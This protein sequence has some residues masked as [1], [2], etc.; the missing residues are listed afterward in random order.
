MWQRLGLIAA[1]LTPAASAR[2]QSAE[3]QQEFVRGLTALHEFEYEEA[4][5]AFMK[6][7][8][9]D[10]GF[11][12]AY[13]GEAM[14]YHQSLWRHENVEMGR[15]ALRRLGPTPAARA[16]KMRTPKEAGLFGAVEVLF[17]PGD[18]AARRRLYADEMARVYARNPADPDV[19]SLY[20]L[21]LLATL[22][23]SLI[24]STDAHEGYSQGLA[25][26]DTQTRV[27]AIL[28]DVLKSHPDHRG[29]L[30][31][32]LHTYDDPQH[33][34]LALPAA[35]AYSKI[36]SESSH[37]MH[38]PSHIFL[39]LG[40][41]Q[42]AASSDR[43]AFDASNRS[44]TRKGLSPALRSY[45]ALS[46]L[47]YE[48]LQLG[49]YR[50]AL[51]TIGE[52]EPVVKST[53]NLT[54]LSDLSSMRARYAVETERWSLMAKER[55][56]GNV[57]DLFAIGLSAAR[58]G[59]ADSAET[60]RKTL[61]DRALAQEEGDLR[62][63]IAI[64]E[65]ELSGVIALAAGRSDEATATLEAAARA[66]LGL[67]PPLGLPAPIKPAPELL[68]EVLLQAG[69]PADAVEWFN[70]AVAR[71]ANRSRSVLGLARAEAALGRR[72][73]ARKHYQ[74]LLANFEHADGD[75][76]ELAE[77][78]P[79]LR[80]TVAPPTA[81]DVRVLVFVFGTS[82]AIA[83]AL[84]VRRRYRREKDRPAPLKGAG[85]GRRTKTKR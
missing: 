78:R 82:A 54:L 45:H 81:I 4:N 35:R 70:R 42:E 24:G 69:K 16:G 5:E 32:L 64:M 48:L 66:E 68:A 10:P 79:A 36:P 37:A 20:A 27:A 18:A 34:H 31:Y 12:M 52:I 6:A 61:A 15:Q 53:G 51:D 55:T 80:T 47:Q 63:A 65:R 74:Q 30:H 3:A 26:S 67:P 72:D 41:W 38:M 40:M 71:H 73:E 14:T 23:R 19:G 17:G 11:A 83:V 76:P 25:G 59:N 85:P 2:A 13:W 29:A 43:A 49:R 56:F 75:V 9:L 58:T 33:A 44:V 60:V 50:E 46:W 1:L 7:R 84:L 28:N 22:S 39:Q 77:A 8:T 21:S 62:P 57:Y